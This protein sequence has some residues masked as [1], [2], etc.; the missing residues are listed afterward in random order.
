MTQ[1]Y[2]KKVFEYNDGFLIWKIQMRRGIKGEIAGGVNQ[3]SGRR[4]IGL[5]GKRWM[6]H[7]LIF[8]YHNG[9]IPGLIDH[10]DQDITN[11]KIE[12]LRPA[13]KSENGSNRGK[14]I[15][16]TSG[17]KGVWFKKSCRKW[18]ATIQKNRKSMHLGV[19]ETPELAS[20]AYKA[21]ALIHH[22]EFAN[23]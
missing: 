13:N 5:N 22:K 12:N 10:I 16:N 2:L 11:N 15:R 3:S 14:T 1:E 21:A 18:G 7:R 8:L 4:T 17:F 6:A 23:G 9:F 19:F 20:K